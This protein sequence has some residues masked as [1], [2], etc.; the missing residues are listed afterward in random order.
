MFSNG[1][2]LNICFVSS[3]WFKWG[4]NRLALQSSR[5]RSRRP[6]PVAF[7]PRF[8]R[9]KG[10]PGK[11][12]ERG[13]FG[14]SAPSQCLTSTSTGTNEEI[15]NFFSADLPR[16]LSSTND[17]VLFLK[18]VV[19][20]G[21]DTGMFSVLCYF[22]INFICHV[23]GCQVCFSFGWWVLFHQASYFWKVLHNWNAY[24]WSLS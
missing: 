14:R 2:L 12:P 17:R 20:E 21:F 5:S 23:W 4:I 6:S 19:A 15:E 3:K 11:K 22:R 9:T 1:V 16:Y 18:I 10:P 7:D 8:E 13:G 24:K